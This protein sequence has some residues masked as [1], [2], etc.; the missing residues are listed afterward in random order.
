[1]TLHFTAHD[2]RALVT[3]DVALA[4]ARDAVQAEAEGETLAVART[5]MPTPRG[6]LRVMPGRFRGIGGMKTMSMTRGVGNRYLLTVYDLTDGDVLAIL[7]A[8]QIT[9]LRTAATTTIAAELLLAGAEPVRLGLL[10]TGFEAT[11][12]LR[13]LAK[14]FPLAEVS[15]YSRDAGRRDRFAGAQSES[16][17]IEVVPVDSPEAA[18]AGTELVCLATKNNRPVVDGAAFAPGAVVLSIGS[19]RPDLRELDERAFARASR[20]LVDSVPGVL[21]ES[22]DVRAA[23]D[24]GVLQQQ[25]I[26][27]MAA[28][29]T[30]P[31]DPTG[32]RIF[33][34]VGTAL[35]DLALAAA[36]IEAASA[37]GRGRELGE[38]AALKPSEAPPRPARA[39][40]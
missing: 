2:V 17:G 5:D 14:R 10:G 30:A 4:A 20:V 27:P 16:L 15:V 6:F 36:V 37:G 33:K 34:S 12:H 29:T 25:Q 26:V 32:L 23:L 1:M 11:G 8:D 39:E 3:G 13:S 31:D 22:G 24:A 21:A 19:T 18:V 40:A 9:R 38:L 28:W 7:D 35:Q